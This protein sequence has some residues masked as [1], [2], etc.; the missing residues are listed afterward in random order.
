M[1]TV[2]GIT[3]TAL[4]TVM[5]VALT[6]IL[7][8]QVSPAPAAG[9]T[10]QWHTTASYQP[11][12][13]VR[14]VS[15][16][17]TPPP[18][19]ATCV[20]VGDDGGHFASIIVTNNGGS[21]WSNA[22]PPAGVTSLSAVSCPSASV[23][24]A[25]GG[26]G[27]IKSSNGGTTWTIQDATFPAQ[28]ISCFTI[29]EC[30]AVGG[31][32][33]A[34]TLDGATWKPQ[35]S[36]TQTNTLSG[37]SC[38]NAI[39]CFAVGMV[40]NQPSIIGQS[41]GITWTVLDQPLLTSLSGISCFVGSIC[42]AVGIAT[43]G[44]GTTL[45]TTNGGSSWV[46]PTSIP[47]G[48]QLDDVACQTSSACIA[49]GTNLTSTPYVIGTA[50][51]GSTWSLQS[52]AAANAVDLTGISCSAQDC[53]AVGDSGNRGAGSTIMVSTTGG[54]SVD[55]PEFPFWHKPADCRRLSH[56]RRLLCCWRELCPDLYQRWILMD[57]GSS[58]CPSKRPQW[59]LVRN[60]LRLHS[61]RFRHLRK[62]NRHR[63][64]EWW[65]H[66]DSR[67]CSI[68]SRHPDGR[69]MRECIGVS[70]SERL[71]L[72]FAQ[73][74]RNGRRRECVVLRELSRHGH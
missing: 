63:H 60:N 53:V 11:L 27:I 66:L 12:A 36:P 1:R 3:V 14:A 45:S 2:R 29:D 30:T 70:R 39:T 54:Q 33:I 57:H 65:R 49:V 35:T 41:D 22:S 61:R 43:N 32:A 51:N 47:T 17:P 20:A 24:Y 8:S 72:R 23:C 9:V 74:H 46:A 7:V 13:N 31:S 69:F 6:S 10:P 34:Q 71:R 56:H 50:N 16:A 62:P 52:Q 55:D 59:G 18:S 38:P 58:S 64:E 37:V 48:K 67:G 28:S 19:P 5:T 26:S 73:H 44:G 15:C 40:N 42:T 25:G 4:S 68:R 21:T